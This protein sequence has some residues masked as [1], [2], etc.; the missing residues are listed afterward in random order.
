MGEA[1]PVH[2]MADDGVNIEGVDSGMRLT[3]RRRLLLP[4][5]DHKRV[6]CWW[7]YK[8]EDDWS[9]FRDSP[10]SESE[11]WSVANWEFFSVFVLAPH[12]ALGDRLGQV[13]FKLDEIFKSPSSRDHWEGSAL[14][15]RAVKTIASSEF[16]FCVGSRGISPDSLFCHLVRQKRP[17]RQQRGMN[18]SGFS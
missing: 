11:S 10:K 2:S 17:R 13:D 7:E 9:S 1:R 12:R 14:I 5:V 3:A 18:K 6:R 4:Q 16:M 8:D 15:N